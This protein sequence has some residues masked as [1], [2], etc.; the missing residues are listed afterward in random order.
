MT[1]LFNFLK[2]IFSSMSE[3]A[4]EVWLLMPIGRM[5][6]EFLVP[7]T[8]LLNLDSSSNTV[9]TSQLKTLALSLADKA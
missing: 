5:L 7:N 2:T 3:V 4:I 8:L 1:R 9:P 6:P